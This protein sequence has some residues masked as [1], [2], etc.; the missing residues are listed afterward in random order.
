VN[1]IWKRVLTVVVVGG[2][3][4]A[5]APGGARA[6]ITPE[7]VKSLPPSAGRTVD[8]AKDIKPIVEASCIKCHG[9]GRVKGGFQFDTR[10]TVLKGGDSGAA[11]V[12]GDSAHSRLIEL[13]AGLD[14]DSV[15]PQKGSKL[16]PEQIGLMRAWIDQGLNW[17]AG[18]DFKRPEPTNLKPH[19]PVIAATR[20]KSGSTNPVDILLETYFSAQ[21]LAAPKPVDDRTFAR[22]LFL[23]VVGLLPTEAEL[24]AFSA[25]RHAD[26]RTRLVQRL[27]AD[28]RR[29]A[30]HWLT[31]W[32]D[33]LR[34]D[35]RGTG[36]IDGG[37]E[38][39]SYWLFSAL[40]RN[41]PYDQFVAQL[42]N[43]NDDS[44]GFTKGFVWRGV[45][46]AS[47]VPQMQ[48]AQNIS[49]VLMGANLKCASCHDSFINDWTLAD[50]YGLAS[51]YADAP[52][53]MFQ[54]DKPTGKVADL[55]FIYPGLGSIDPK[56]PK[57]V[58]LKQLADIITKKENGRLPRTIVNRLW[59][60]FM[61]RGLVEPVDEMDRP[62]WNPDLLDWLAE[63]LVDHRYD[64]KQTMTRILTSE[65]YQ[66]P[67]VG[68]EERASTNFVFRGPSVRRM[69]A[70]EFR[71]AISALTGVWNTLPAAPVDFTGAAPAPLRP[72]PAT[73]K[74]PV[75][76][77]WIWSVPEGAQPGVPLTVYFRKEVVLTE[78]PTEASLIAS[79][80]YRFDVSINGHSATSGQ[81]F[82]RPRLVD[83]KS[84]LV[85]GTNLIAA[86]VSNAPDAREAEKDEKLA[87]IKP[88]KPAGFALYAR[89]RNRT[90]E[91]GIPV[92]KVM[93]FATDDSW[94]WATG[95]FDGWQNS[96]FVPEGWSEAAALGPIGAAPWRLE[97]KWTAAISSAEQYGQVRASLTYSDPLMLCLGRP[98]REQVVT[99]RASTAV[100]LQALELSNGATL[101]KLLDQ[102]VEHLL[103]EQPGTPDE[104]TQ[105]I[106][107]QAL[108]RK[109]TAGELTL[110]EGMVGNPIQKEGVEDLLWAVMMLP[111]FQLIY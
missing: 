31:F 106:W 30:E 100:T 48:A 111:E 61:G 27:L 53:E 68:G 54:C 76:A 17:T 14:P 69:S 10:D 9:R 86:S 1:L 42:I 98:N 36:Y 93:D 13:V 46:N 108:G 101:N 71:D 5:L 44:Q 18:I 45:V 80:D 19:R 4:V 67:S 57:A 91:Q 28:N 56:A 95:K 87:A 37:R 15:M 70:E 29:Y 50:S 41:L 52:M 12:P 92:E 26:K 40:E 73:G 89:V 102:G 20:A 59:A 21:Q 51:I 105:R 75:Q 58:R 90:E 35:Y 97:P 6:A 64:L 77:Q 22:R 107:S 25:D 74:A 33:L 85:K 66:M 81:N 3:F 39:I 109:P 23:D 24:A 2:L 55:K 104:L 11:V 49:Q 43:P 82:K 8:F 63:D 65:A 38:Q 47:Q 103:Q 94:I 16:T 96:N 32:N 78:V 83:I 7:Q 60:R 72:H 110:A 88:S 62:A 34:N 84:M 79:G 99:T